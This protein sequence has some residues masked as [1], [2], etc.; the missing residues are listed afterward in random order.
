VCGKKE[1]K[2]ER[3]RKKEEEERRKKAEHRQ[4]QGKIKNDEPWC[5]K[6]TGDRYRIEQ[7]QGL[8]P[9]CQRLD[10]VGREG[11][12][13]YVVRVGRIALIPALS[14][15]PTRQHHIDTPSFTVIRYQC[16]RAR[17]KETNKLATV[18]D[19]TGAYDLAVSIDD[20]GMTMILSPTPRQKKK[21]KNRI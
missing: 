5:V 9:I 16:A 17:K 13:V 8:D 14:H 1:R 18:L 3:K 7:G 10:G 2:R 6:I 21:K 20:Q 11:W 4:A 12:E 15:F 19:Q